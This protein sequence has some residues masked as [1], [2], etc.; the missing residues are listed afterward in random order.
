M[1]LSIALVVVVVGLLGLFSSSVNGTRG[2]AIHAHSI[3][4]DKAVCLVGGVVLFLEKREANGWDFW[5]LIESVV[6]CAVAA[7]A[8]LRIA[9]TCDKLFTCLQCATNTSCGWCNSLDACV[10]GDPNGAFG[11]CPSGWAWTQ[12]DCADPCLTYSSCKTCNINSQCGWCQG[13]STCKTG[14]LQGPNSGVC[15]SWSFNAGCVS[16]FPDT[17]GWAAVWR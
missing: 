5:S 17:I 7:G 2:R 4:R 13:L 11:L 9:A 14:S 8:G 3:D 1:R 15:P 12:Q 16:T 10:P 6:W